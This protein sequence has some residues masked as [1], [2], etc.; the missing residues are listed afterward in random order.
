MRLLPDFALNSRLN[1]FSYLQPPSWADPL[2]LPE[3][4]PLRHVFDQED[5]IGVIEDHSP[6]GD[7]DRPW[8]EAQHSSLL[9]VRR[10]QRSLLL[11]GLFPQGVH[12]RQGGLFRRF[13]LL[14]QGALDELEA[15]DK[16]LR[17][18]MQRL[19]RIDL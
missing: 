8:G 9:P 19:I 13:P 11:L 2:A 7:D 17:G 1:A 12:L 15:F 16:L 5:L 4:P 6:H 3:A 14:A 10:Q 18:L